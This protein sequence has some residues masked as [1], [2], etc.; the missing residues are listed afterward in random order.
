MTLERLI[1]GI[2]IAWGLREH[3]RRVKLEAFAR[4]AVPLVADQLRARGY[5]Q[6]LNYEQSREI[7]QDLQGLYTN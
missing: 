7:A 3:D 1:I 5:C 2:L 6:G 4:L